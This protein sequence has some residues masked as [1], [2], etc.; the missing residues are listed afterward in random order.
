MPRLIKEVSLKLKASEM[1]LQLRDPICVGEVRLLHQAMSAWG[2]QNADQETPS[3]YRVRLGREH[4][5]QLFVWPGND[6]KQELVFTGFKKEDGIKSISL[7]IKPELIGCR[8]CFAKNLIKSKMERY[9]QIAARAIQSFLTDPNLS[10]NL[11]RPQSGGLGRQGWRTLVALPL[12]QIPA[13]WMR[14]TDLLANTR[15]TLP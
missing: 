2:K 14:T 11:E 6:I 9:Q 8:I 1:C 12:N 7:L 5:L 13:D 10:L 4:G 3:P 15:V